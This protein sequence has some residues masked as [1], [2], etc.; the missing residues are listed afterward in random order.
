[1]NVND[2]KL[3][4]AGPVVTDSETT[5][6]IESVYQRLRCHFETYR[7]RLH[8]VL[9]EWGINIETWG[10][11]VF[12]MDIVAIDN[13]DWIVV[14]NFGCDHQTAGTAWECGYAFAKGKKILVINM[15]GSEKDS[16]IMVTGCAANIINYSDFMNTVEIEK[17]FY[18]R[19]RIKQNV[20]LN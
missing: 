7:P 4:L 2:Y 20:V 12:T 14:C 16:S 10:Q 1:M 18:E 11:C 13:A 17:L 19:G 3:Y 9:N 5:K 15:P 8:K 6:L